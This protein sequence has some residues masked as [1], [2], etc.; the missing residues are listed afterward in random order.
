MLGGTFA[1]VCIPP[2]II[3]MLRS[4]FDDTTPV[5]RMKRHRIIRSE[6][7][8]RHPPVELTLW[9]RIPG[10]AVRMMRISNA[11]SQIVARKGAAQAWDILVG[12]IGRAAK[13][14]KH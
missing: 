4:V 5:M 6:W 7:V 2:I 8:N 3:E 13:S 12:L 1:A 9:R 14:T 11:G 10:I